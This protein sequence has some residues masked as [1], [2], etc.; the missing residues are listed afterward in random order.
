MNHALESFVDPAF[1]YDFWSGPG[2]IR[3]RE[4]ALAQGIN[5]IS[6]THLVLKDM[7]GTTLPPNLH[8]YELF[9]DRQYFTAVQDQE[10]HAGDLAWFGVEHP[11]TTA[12]AFKPCYKNSLLVNWSDFPIKHVAIHTGEADEQGDPLLLHTT[13][14]TGT[15]SLWPLRQFRVY[16]RYRKR[17]GTTR[18]VTH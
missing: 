9:S 7:F 15:T 4:D 1:V 5:C 18:L 13:S 11:I 2:T 17:Y 10:A 16:R 14:I 3:S 6:L 12:E 8:C